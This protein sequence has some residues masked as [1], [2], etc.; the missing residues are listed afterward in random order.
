MALGLLLTGGLVFAR[1]AAVV[2]MLPG[3]GAAK[4]PMQIKLLLTVALTT[5]I[6]PHVPAY[7]QAPTLLV[8]LSSMISEMLL[9]GL[10]GGAVALVFGG[11]AFAT[12]IIGAQTG[13]AVALQFYPMLEIS[14]GPIGAIAGMMATLVFMGLGQHLMVLVILSESFHVV[15]PGSG[16]DIQATAEVYTAMAS[17]VLFSGLQLAGPAVVLVFLVNSFVAVLARLAPSMNVFFS[18]GFLLTMLAGMALFLVSFPHF[19]EIHTR[20]VD[21]L[22]QRLPDMIEAAGGG[23]GG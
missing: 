22:L 7:T 16:I 8:M 2:A 14:Q 17:P 20:M 3:I 5:L 15:P 12:E 4:T 6:V 1:L 10:M 18:I 21:D 11:L 23:N 9:G 19:L 13:R